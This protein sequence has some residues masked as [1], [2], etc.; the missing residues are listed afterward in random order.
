MSLV[1]FNGAS[2]S[3]FIC[4]KLLEGGVRVDGD[5]IITQRKKRLK[6]TSENLKYC[7][8]KLFYNLKYEAEEDEVSDM[9]IDFRYIFDNEL[10]EEEESEL[11]ELENDDEEVDENNNQPLINALLK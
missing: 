9:I 8:E 10:I 7:I 4:E 2:K 11:E 6:Y 5:Y 1:D 3:F